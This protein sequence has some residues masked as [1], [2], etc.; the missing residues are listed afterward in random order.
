MSAV[1]Q[2]GLA[3]QGLFAVPDFRRLWGVGLVVFVV[4]WLETLAISLF[5]YNA[6]GSAF[7]VAMM[8]MLRLLPMGL[9]GAFLGAWAERVEPRTGLLAI[10]L[11][12]LLTSLALAV[13]AQAG[14]LAVWHLA[15]ASLV[16][17]LAWA[18]DNPVRRLAIGQVAGGARMGQAMS[19]DVGT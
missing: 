5:V 19:V 16:N 13:L 12:S 11:S 6:T 3:R 2:P 7:L 10:V 4:R 1:T 8:T 15:V 17:G 18:A 9:L 14:A